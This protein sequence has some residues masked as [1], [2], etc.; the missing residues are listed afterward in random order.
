MARAVLIA[1]GLAA[2]GVATMQACTA[3]AGRDDVSIV[4]LETLI[5]DRAIECGCEQIEPA[6]CQVAFT[7]GIER[8]FDPECLD[9]WSDWLEGFQCQAPPMD[10]WPIS[11]P[12]YYGTSADGEPC[13]LIGILSDCTRGSICLHGTCTTTSTIDLDA[14]GQLD[15]PCD[16]LGQCGD[17]IAVCID[18]R[19]ER[20]PGPGQPC[21][22]VDCTPGS[23]CEFDVDRRNT[24]C[25]EGFA[26]GQ[27]CTGHLQ[28]ASRNCPAGRCRPPS[29]QGDPCS[30]NLPCGPGFSCVGNRCEPRGSVGTNGSI[31]ELLDPV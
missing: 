23:R 3:G 29:G 11:C 6:Q 21:G 15:G 7:D 27:P 14:L 31:C 25:V 16:P 20:R 8:T 5:C 12:V 22:Q 4:R 19:C 28:C 2:A 10:A 13:N 9:T 1:L 18:N 30:G 24:I 26:D 17:P